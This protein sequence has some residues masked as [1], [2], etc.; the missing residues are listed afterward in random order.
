MTRL[1]RPAEAIEPLRQAVAG[2]PLDLIAAR[3]LFSALGVVGD[4][5]HAEAIP[6]LRESLDLASLDLS[7][8]PKLY[9][10]V[11]RCHQAL[12]QGQEAL[13]LCRKGREQFPGDVELLSLE[14]LLLQEAGDFAGAEARFQ[15]L[16]QTRPGQYFGSFDLGILTYKTRHQLALLYHQ[17]GR[18]AEAEAQ[19]RAVVQ[20]QPQFWPAWQG[21]KEI[22]AK[23][24]PETDQK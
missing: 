4:G 16:L 8:R 7:I 12:G 14:G 15:Q 22:G 5:R 20:E 11:G 6:L 24:D 19:W 3:T 1:G 17:Q 9:W 21:L 18:L 2:N 23:K 13:F 10:L